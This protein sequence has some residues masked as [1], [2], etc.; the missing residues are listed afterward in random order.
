MSVFLVMKLALSKSKTP[1]EVCETPSPDHTSFREIPLGKKRV[2]EPRGKKHQNIK[3]NSKRAL[4]VPRCW[5]GWVS[6]YCGCYGGSGIAEGGSRGY[7]GVMLILMMLPS[8]VLK[9]RKGWEIIHPSL[10]S[11]MQISSSM[12]ASSF[13]FPSTVLLILTPQF[14]F[15]PLATFSQPIDTTN[16]VSRVAGFTGHTGTTAGCLLA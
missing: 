12:P 1:R 15:S 4:C 2:F 8:Y 7:C 5:E 14:S 6:H 3:A 16:D 10:H 11:E 13:P 9:V